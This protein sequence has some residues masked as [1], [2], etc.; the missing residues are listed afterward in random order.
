[1]SCL[2]F[3][4]CSFARFFDSF[5]ITG[6]PDPAGFPPELIPQPGFIVRFTTPVDGKHLLGKMM[7]G[8]VEKKHEGKVYFM[9]PGIDLGQ[10]VESGLTAMMAGHVADDRTVLFA[11]EPLLQKMLTAS[12][13]KS[14]LLE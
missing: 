11:A 8:M 13:V 14:P 4:G 1:M 9:L 7:P 3:S 5:Q 6:A 12:D 10:P 2:S